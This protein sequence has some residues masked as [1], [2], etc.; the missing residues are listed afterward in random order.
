MSNSRLRR[1]IK[2]DAVLSIRRLTRDDAGLGMTEI[3]VAIMVFAIIATTAAYGMVNGLTLTQYSRASETAMSIASS[4]LDQMRLTASSD[5]DGVFSVLSTTS[6][7]TQ[8]VGGTKFSITRL[9][10]WQTTDGTTG[11]C[12]TG[13]GT[14]QYKNVT[15]TVS[16]P[17]K[18]GGTR[19]VT[20]ASAI[21][22]LS[23]INS[24]AT[25]TIIV[26]IQGAAGQPV[27]GVKV[28]IT[29]I[30][31]G[32]GS[33][34]DDAPQNTDNVGCSFGLLVDPGTYTVTAT[35]AG[36]IDYN[37]NTTATTSS[38]VSVVAGQNTIVNFSYDK[39]AAFPLTYPTGATLPT[40][41]PISF[42][43]STPGT[44]PFSGTTPPTSVNAFPWGDGYTII[45]GSYVYTAATS[46]ASCLDTNPASW[47]TP[48][49]GDGA[50]GVP[51]TPVAAAAGST[52]AST[53]VPLGTFTLSNLSGL[54]NK[55]ITAV[56]A[57]PTAGDPGCNAGQ[58]LY[59]PKITNASGSLTLALPYGTWKLYAGSTQGAQT[60]ALPSGGNGV[61]G[62]LLGGI[63][64][65]LGGGANSITLDPR[66]VS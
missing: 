63:L 50:V 2:N 18:G 19:S 34:L 56:T 28:S 37:Q 25:G 31:G 5:D 46:T 61:I 8:T 11:A 66:V 29:P 41:L 24:D 55:Y 7:I 33:A 9:V 13:T 22:P 4:D 26:T 21:A 65:S 44:T 35:L 59:F 54:V 48:R 1:R 52:A 30:S 6:P 20:L 47:T 64:T 43:H 14:L 36:D 17:T 23:N 10:S 38:P 42:Y 32:G 57:T 3:I 39:S 40:N 27:P 58:T 49:V 53:A 62:V 12:G 51:L 16:W 15:E 45:G 60:T